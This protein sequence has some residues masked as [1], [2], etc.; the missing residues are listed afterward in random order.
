MPAHFSLKR[1]VQFHE[2]DMAGV[3]HFANYFRMMEEVEHGF[4]RNLG[5]SIVMTHEA[6]EIGWPRVAA[7]CEY[8]GPLR[9]EDEV[10]L[11]MRV[12]K[13]GEKSFNYE[14]EFQ[15]EGR[16]VALGKMTSV[17]CEMLDAGMRSIAIPPGI[18][19]KLE[20]E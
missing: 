9:F 15:W 17:C 3:V 19:K 6:L 13:V 8:F 18:R 14:V 1:R 20:G 5:L 16:R 10:E 12:T 11:I 2:T 4:F 7:S